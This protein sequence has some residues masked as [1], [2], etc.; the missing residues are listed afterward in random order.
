MAA[1]VKMTSGEHRKC[2]SSSTLSLLLYTGTKFTHKLQSYFWNNHPLFRLWNQNPASPSCACPKPSSTPNS[3]DYNPTFAP[4][5]LFGK[6]TPQM[7]VMAELWMLTVN[8]ASC[9]EWTGIN[10]NILQ[11]NKQECAYC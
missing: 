4:H 2:H 6:G 3:E 10:S 7:H 9:E 5:F 11:P 1:A 8:N